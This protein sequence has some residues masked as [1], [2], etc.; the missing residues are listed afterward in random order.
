MLNHFFGCFHIIRPLIFSKEQNEKESVV[1][2]L[3][4][5]LLLNFV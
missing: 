1:K 5:D 3:Q 4:I 2:H